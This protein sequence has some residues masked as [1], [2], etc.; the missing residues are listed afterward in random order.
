[1]QNIPPKGI[2]EAL[3]N[4]ILCRQPEILAAKPGLK[5]NFPSL[6]K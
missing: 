5:T 3:E 1:M 4:P 6:R 2:I